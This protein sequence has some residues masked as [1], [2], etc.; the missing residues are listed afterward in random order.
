[1]RDKREVLQKYQEVR[2]DRLRKRKEAFLSKLPR[3]CQHNTRMRVKGQGSVGFCQN[4][5]ILQRAKTKVFVCNDEDTAKRCRVFSCRNSHQSVEDD[6]NEVIG[7]PARC[8]HD[9]P[10][11]AMLIWFLQNYPNGS[12]GARFWYEAGRIFIS[13]WRVLTFKWW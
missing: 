11:L 7:S 12:R 4:P 1:M 9:Y 8:G 5:I 13:L 3:N 10:K 6:F 2:A